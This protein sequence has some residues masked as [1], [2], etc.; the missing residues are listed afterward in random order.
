MELA[1]DGVVL[2]PDFS[3]D[4]FGFQEGTEL[5]LIATGDAV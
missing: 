5:V 2:T 4:N 3:L 1:H